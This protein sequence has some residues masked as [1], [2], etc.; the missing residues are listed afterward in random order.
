MRAV[1]HYIDKRS[2]FE[3]VWCAKDAEALAWCEILHAVETTGKARRCVVCSWLFLYPS[4]YPVKRC[5]SCQNLNWRH[6][7]KIM[8]LPES[9]RFARVK[10]AYDEAKRKGRTI[11]DAWK[12]VKEAFP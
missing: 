5:L 10:M 6:L 11:E 8:R 2:Q 12:T 4:A 7:E 9:V 1:D 3:M